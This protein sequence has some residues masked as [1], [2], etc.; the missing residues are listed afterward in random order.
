MGGLPQMVF[1]FIP[2]P[3]EIEAAKTERPG[4]LLDGSLL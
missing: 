1:H 3:N 2:M 4:I